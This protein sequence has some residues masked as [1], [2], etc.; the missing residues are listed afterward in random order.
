M[1]M[2]WSPIYSLLGY[3]FANIPASARRGNS[4]SQE[5]PYD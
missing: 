5:F 2:I 3:Y 4:E 1:M